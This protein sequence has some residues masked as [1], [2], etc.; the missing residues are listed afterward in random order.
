M[1]SVTHDI[2]RPALTGMV[3]VSFRKLHMPTLRLK[4][5]SV[6]SN[7]RAIRVSERGRRDGEEG[8]EEEG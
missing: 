2:T 3:H 8:G 4:S 6:S 1:A 7:S 5:N